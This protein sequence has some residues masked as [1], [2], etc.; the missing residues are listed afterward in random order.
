MSATAVFSTVSQ[1]GFLDSLRPLVTVDSR[2]LSNL[3][4]GE[5]EK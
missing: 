3:R 5:G 4:R 1:S 2:A